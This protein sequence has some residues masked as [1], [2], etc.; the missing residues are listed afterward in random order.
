MVRVHLPLGRNTYLLFNFDIVNVVRKTDE[1]QAESIGSLNFVLLP[2]FNRSWIKG[3]G[4]RQIVL[5]RA[6]RYCI[7]FQPGF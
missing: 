7:F 2:C 3:C 1:G 4:V 5:F 6:C